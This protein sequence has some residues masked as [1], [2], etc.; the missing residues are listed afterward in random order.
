MEEYLNKLVYSS[1]VKMDSD[2]L[3]RIILEQEDSSLQSP[4]VPAHYYRFFY[5]LVQDLKPSLIIELGT[6]FGHSSA[7][8]AEGNPAGK[9][10]TINNRKELRE[11]CRRANV[12]YLIQ[13]SLTELTLNEKAGILFI[14]TEHDG[15]RCAAEYRMHLKHVKPGGLVFFDDIHLFECMDKFWKD[16]NPVEGKKFEL[17][18]H[19]KAGFGVV[20]LDEAQEGLK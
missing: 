16:F 2:D 10:I 19:G 18:V 3:E 6:S 12:E 8:L 20:L 14:D 7:C 9:V 15:I 17:P 11:S 5:R 4:G 13:D 1:Q